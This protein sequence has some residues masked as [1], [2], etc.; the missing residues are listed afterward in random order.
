MTQLSKHIGALASANAITIDKNYC[1]QTQ[2]KLYTF[3][4]NGNS[5]GRR[6]EKEKENEEC[7]RVERL[8]I[9]S[10]NYGV[11]SFVN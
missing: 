5:E 9:Q 10:S 7:T 4:D 2:T 11:L 3:N 8:P 6:S 1:F